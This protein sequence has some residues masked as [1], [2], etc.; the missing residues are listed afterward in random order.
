MPA[1]Q[2]PGL[3]L[4]PRC[5]GLLAAGPPTRLYPQPWATAAL[6]LQPPHL[7]KPSPHTRAC[8]PEVGAV[9]GGRAKVLG[10]AAVE[11]QGGAALRGQGDHHGGVAAVAGGGKVWV[12][13]QPGLQGVLF[14]EGG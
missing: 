7:A 11:L 14:S 12:L 4:Q 1:C 10:E 13:E 3:V 5:A 2:S 6:Q 8:C 9:V